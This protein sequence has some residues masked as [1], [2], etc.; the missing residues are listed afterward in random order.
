ME[1]VSEVSGIA[2]TLSSTLEERE[3]K[4][5]LK[6]GEIIRVA[7]IWQK[8]VTKW[9][10]LQQAKDADTRDI[11]VGRLVEKGKEST[12]S[13]TSY[14]FHNHHFLVYWSK[15]GLDYLSVCK[16]PGHFAS[17]ILLHPELHVWP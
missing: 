7:C 12:K 16:E 9:E 15:Q 1:I 6:K 3:L 11:K 14:I 5:N 8:P 13:F 10:K 4:D 2:W 17:H